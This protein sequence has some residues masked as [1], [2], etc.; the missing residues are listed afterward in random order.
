MFPAL[1][2]AQSEMDPDNDGASEELGEY[3]DP[4]M[5][6]AAAPLPEPE[7]DD[8]PRPPVAQPLPPDGGVVKQAGVGGQTA[9]GRAGVLELGGFAGFTS[10]SN[11]TSATLNPTIGWFFAENVQLSGILGVSHISTDD[12]S[13]TMFSAL[14]EP[15]YHLPFNRSVF[16]FMGFGVGG[17]HAPE[18]GFGFAIAPRL[19]ANIM[20]GRSGI[21]TPSLSYQYTSHDT[22][23]M[24]D[25]SAVVVSTALAA[26]IGYTVMW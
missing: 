11:F 10:A 17:A 13:A 5:D 8:D 22:I 20:V 21:L 4:S 25:S 6:E 3:E 14:V 23:E 7:T 26:N 16:G 18:A 9:Y 15:S 24:Q 12:N 1:A 19:G 2:S